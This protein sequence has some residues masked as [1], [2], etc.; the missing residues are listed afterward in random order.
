MGRFA[1]DAVA[2]AGRAGL[3]WL[4]AGLQEFEQ[5]QAPNERGLSRVDDRQASLDPATHGWLSGADSARS[6]VHRV[7]EVHLDSSP[8]RAVA[9]HALSIRSHRRKTGQEG[10]EI[11]AQD[12]RPLAELA[13]PQAAIGYRLIDF[14]APDSGNAAGFQNRQT[15]TLKIMRFS[16]H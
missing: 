15:F 8:V 9:S 13:R 11:S 4:R 12:Q 7:A 5:V 16:V 6:L 3:L 2:K 1:L 10:L 14:C